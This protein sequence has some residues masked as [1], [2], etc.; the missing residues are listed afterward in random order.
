MAVAIGHIMMIAILQQKCHCFTVGYG[1]N[2][3]MADVITEAL[4]E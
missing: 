4:L 3:T 2:E 1:T